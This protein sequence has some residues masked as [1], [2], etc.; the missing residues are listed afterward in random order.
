M[1]IFYLILA[2]SLL[3]GLLFIYVCFVLKS[4]LYRLVLFS[5]GS[6]AIFLTENKYS[7]R[8]I[9]TIF[10]TASKEDLRFQTSPYSFQGYA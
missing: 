4:L 6:P 2:Q 7:L 5:S 10:Q 1:V 3:E 8:A 9:A